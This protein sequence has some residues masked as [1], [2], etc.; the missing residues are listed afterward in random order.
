MSL[1][2]RYR[3][4]DFTTLVGQDFV[5]ESL[6]HALREE[7]KIVGAYLFH[8]SRGTGKTSVARIFAKAMNCDSLLPDGNPCLK[9]SHCEEFQNGE[10]LDV[11]EIDAASNT[12]VDNVREL[13]ERS[14]FAPSRG[15]YK[16]YIIDEVHMLSKGAFNALLKTL[17]EPPSHIR[18]ILATTEIYKVPDTIISRV[19]RYDFR[20]IAEELIHGRLRYI[21]NAEGIVVDDGSL[22]LLARIAHGGMRDAITLMEQ[23]TISGTLTLATLE[24][25]L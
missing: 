13:I 21:A 8:G 16:V 7:G 5:K 19:Q 9:C 18:F 25:N 11:V 12:S 24:E 10:Y 20:P 2:R 3:P 23:Y 17:E 6:M 14:R 1:Y 15:R 22:A 4:Q